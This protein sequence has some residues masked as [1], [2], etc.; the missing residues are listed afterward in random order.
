VTES[1]PEATASL[2]RRWHDG[3]AQALGAIL[4]RDAGWIAEQVRRHMGPALRG[5]EETQD[6]VQDAILRVLRGGP[7]FVVADARH[8]RALLARIVVNLLRD[9]ARW[10][11]AGRRALGHER[12]A[13]PATLLDLDAGSRTTQDPAVQ[14]DRAER[15]EWIRLAL[16]FLEPEDRDVI[17][18][19]DWE[20][21]SFAEIGARLGLGDD[22]ARMRYLRAL[23]RLAEQVLELRRGRLGRLLG[24]APETPA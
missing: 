14:L 10:R 22:G 20:E 6:I 19:R 2:L 9:R 21:R 24:A 11:D 16:E 4:A 3:D 5:A 17:V 12:L 23:P 8:F 15:R 18:L 1:L 13:G 7:R